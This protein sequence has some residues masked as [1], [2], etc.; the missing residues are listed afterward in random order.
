MTKSVLEQQI[1]L[2]TIR[3]EE[4]EMEYTFQR[5]RVNFDDLRIIRYKIDSFSGLIRD[6]ENKL[7][8]LQ[9]TDYE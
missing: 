6:Y 7:S 9:S 4:L 3:K 1:A 2:A 8:H 5:G